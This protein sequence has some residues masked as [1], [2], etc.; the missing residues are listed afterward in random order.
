M[1]QKTPSDRAYACRTAFLLVICPVILSNS[2][3]DLHPFRHSISESY[4]YRWCRFFRPVDICRVQCS[5]FGSFAV[6]GQSDSF[7]AGTFPRQILHDGIEVAAGDRLVIVH[8]AGIIRSSQVYRL[9][10]SRVLSAA[11]IRYSSPTS[12]SESTVRA[13]RS[14]ASFRFLHIFTQMPFSSSLCSHCT[15]CVIG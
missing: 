2:V 7:L 8:I 4:T 5:C 13:S 3:S 11:D 10:G 6:C 9:S 1:P 15:N 12:A 14:T